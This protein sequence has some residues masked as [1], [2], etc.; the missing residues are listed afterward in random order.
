[1]TSRE[2][3]KRIKKLK[4]YDD[5]YYNTDTPLVSDKKYDKFREETLAML[6][7]SDEKIPEAKKYFKG[8]RATVRESKRSE[9]LPIVLGSLK[10]AKNDNNSLDRFIAKALEASKALSASMDKKLRKHYEALVAISISPKLDGLTF[11]LHYENGKLV[12]AYSGGDGVK[13]QNKD[14]HALELALRGTIPK[15]IP[16]KNPRYIIGE[17][18]CSKKKFQKILDKQDKKNSRYNEVRNA[19]SGW[20]NADTPPVA[21]AKAINFIAYDIKTPDGE[22]GVKKDIKELDLGSSKRAN[23][24]YTIQT[25]K[26][27]GFNTYAGSSLHQVATVAANDKSLRK[28]LDSMLTKLEDYDYPL[29]GLVVEVS[30]AHIRHA[31]GTDRHG[32]PKFAVAY[33][34]SADSAVASGH[35]VLT[36]VRK[37]KVNTSKT[38]ALKPTLVYEPIKIG[39]A[40]YKK[41]TGNNFAYLLKNGIGVGTKISIVKAGDVIPKAYFADRKKATKGEIYVDSCECGASS[42]EVKTEAGKILPDLYCKLGSKCEFAKYQQLL[43]AIKA[44]KVT[45]LGGKNVRKLFDA[46]YTDILELMESVKNKKDLAKLKSIE[47]FGD[48]MLS[49]LKTGLP[50]SLSKMKFAQLMLLSNVFSR[51]GLSLAQAAFTDNEKALE[52]ATRKGKIRL[53]DC[54][55]MLGKEKGKLLYE[56]FPKWLNFYNKLY[57]LIEG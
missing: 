49:T 6:K 37:I 43:G 9:T 26:S 42:R 23:K 11:L 33:K 16:H 38:G 10:K 40:T 1:M 25:L 28:L 48:S 8:V 50:K 7:A 21:L 5:A 22:L 57:K 44:T 51:P 4:E 30:D 2:I 46:G 17:I 47:G 36:K 29:D 45:G 39:N 20:V 52:K 3:L 32:T 35:G 13:G 53:D 54:I 55:E 15:S 31:M 14:A 19:A 56:R 18:V 27:W 12:K 34:V 41:A 24:I